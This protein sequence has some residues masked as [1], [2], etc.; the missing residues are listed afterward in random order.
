MSRRRWNVFFEFR[1]T[2]ARV[3]D[4]AHILSNRHGWDSR[5]TIIG[6]RHLLLVWHW[7]PSDSREAS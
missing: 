1:S 2:L 5:V 7:H 6:T 3:R 4:A